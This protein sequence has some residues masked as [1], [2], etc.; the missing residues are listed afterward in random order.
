MWFCILFIVT[1]CVFGLGLVVP[2]CVGILLVYRSCFVLKE[3]C[4]LVIFL[5]GSGEF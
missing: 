5:V 2:L 1:L 4:L 3:K